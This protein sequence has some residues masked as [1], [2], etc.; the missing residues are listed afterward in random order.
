MKITIS[1]PHKVA[2]FTAIFHNLKQFSDNMVIYFNPDNFYI[3]G[4]DG[5]HCCLFE[6]KLT[7]QWFDN[8]DYDGIL[9]EESLATYH[10]DQLKAQLEE[11]KQRVE[12]MRKEVTRD[13]K[14]R[15]NTGYNQAL[16]DLIKT[17]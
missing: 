2:H 7:S 9:D 10:V 4:L 17:L 6:C 1:E 14:D 15:N 13:W 5:C 16:E 12:G 3:Q 11:I 8:Y